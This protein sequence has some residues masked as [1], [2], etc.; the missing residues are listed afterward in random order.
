[1]ASPA[2]KL[3]DVEALRA[4]QSPKA[5][6]LSDLASLVRE[7]AARAK[8][9]ALAKEADGLYVST[10]EGLKGARGAMMAIGL[11]AVAA[12]IFYGIWQAWHALR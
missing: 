7:E 4:P 9:A 1:M 5:C 8:E 2:L 3:T 11:E 12:L 10:S 6:S